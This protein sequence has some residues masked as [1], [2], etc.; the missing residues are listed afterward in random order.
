MIADGDTDVVYVAD[1]LG[2]RFPEVHRG[3]TSI[4]R[5][6]GIPLRAIPGTRQVWCR[7]FMPIQVADERFVQFRYAPDY[8]VGRYRHLR[9]DG[10]IGPKLPWVRN[11]L[12]SGAVLDGGNVVRWRD[13]VIMT[14]KAFAENRGWVRRE[15]LA[16]LE[17]LFEVGQV[18]VI[19][20]EQGDV[21][22]HADGVVRFVAETTVVLNDYRRLDPGYRGVLRRRLRRAGLE[23][24]EVPYRPAP[25][26]SGG[27]P[28]AV[29][30][31]INYLRVGRLIVIPCFGLP[32]DE[33]ARASLA[34]AHPGVV[35]ENLECRELAA[36]G[37]VLN[38][39]TW[40]VRDNA[41]L[42]SL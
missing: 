12:R 8:L 35:I 3:L 9:A 7:D 4:L 34:E 31:Y 40:T 22:G 32:E 36:E 5:D 18:V 15:L 41:V 2:R 13:K 33:R 39:S 37:G 30:N 25:E 1:T 14:E 29:G 16:E 20:P 38:C 11:C 26:S 42:D 28:S 24:L 19:P 23:V 10:E 21:T 17:Q 6:H 27:M